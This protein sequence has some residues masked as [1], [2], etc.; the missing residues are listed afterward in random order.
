MRP[1]CDQLASLWQKKWILVAVAVV[2]VAVVALI[3]GLSV[4]K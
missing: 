4:G 1:G 2:L 3:I